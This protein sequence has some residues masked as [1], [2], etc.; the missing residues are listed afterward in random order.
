MKRNLHRLAGLLFWTYAAFY[1]VVVFCYF[2][3]IPSSQ[4]LSKFVLAYPEVRS[5]VN[6]NFFTALFGAFAGAV[7]AQVIA[8][9]LERKELIL[10]EIR[11]VNAAISI[12]FNICNSA[13][14][15]KK[16]NVLGL[17]ENYKE[18]RERVINIIRRNVESEQIS[19]KKDLHIIPA[20]ELPVAELKN[21]IFDK[22][23]LVGKGLTLAI[24]IEQNLKSLNQSL[25]FRNRLIHA[26][27][28]DNQTLDDY[29]YLGIPSPQGHLDTQYQS[30]LEGIEIYLDMVIKASSLLCD[31][32]TMHGYELREALG[33]NS[34]SI[35]K[36]EI[37]KEFKKYVPDTSEILA[38]EEG[39]S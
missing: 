4:I 20:L 26:H 16:Q 1:A 10:Q 34:L 17:I 2:N 23:N 25:D 24:T 5:F 6:S 18:T 33:D 7:G 29:S 27:R 13:I 19:Y 11:N 15:L 28:T 35:Y 37:K 31:V 39:L 12:C 21:K 9:K 8:E 38:W 22:T 14:G 3:K 32:L 30:S 36:V